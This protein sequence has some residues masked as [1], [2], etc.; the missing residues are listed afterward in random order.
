MILG[1]NR[2]NGRYGILSGD[3]WVDDGLHC[4]QALEV[5][6]PDGTILA[7]LEMNGDGE[8]YLAGTGLSGSDLEG[9]KV[10]LPGKEDK[11]VY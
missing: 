5:E 9:L 1:I 7:R 4:G 8:W 10:H 6:T 2:E 3:L 11:V